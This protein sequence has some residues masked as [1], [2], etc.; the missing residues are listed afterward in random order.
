MDYIAELK[1]RLISGAGL[2]VAGRVLA[3][4]LSF[5]MSAVLAR[6]LSPSD[7]GVYFLMYS[8]VSILAIV[9]QGGLGSA[10]VSLVAAENA[11]GSEKRARELALCALSMGVAVS[12]I[13][14]SLPYTDHGSRIIR[15]VLRSERAAEMPGLL[16]AWVWGMAMTNLIAD[17]YRGF[18]D[19]RSA[20]QY[21]GLLSTGIAFVVLVGF[22]FLERVTLESVVAATVVGVVMSTL[23]GGVPLWQGLR[24]RIAHGFR[25][26]R[27][28]IG[29]AWPLFVTSVGLLVINQ[30]DI[31]ILNA[32]RPH[33]EVATYGAAT[34]LILFA[35]TP[36]VIAYAVIP[37]MIAE[38]H[39]QHR[40]KTLERLLRGVSTVTGLPGF[41]VIG[42]YIVFPNEIMALVYGQYY[43]QGADVLA[44]LAAGNIMVMLSGMAS[45]A[46]M[47]TG[48]Q[49]LMMV[50]TVASGILSVLL[51]LAFVMAYGNEGVAIAVA[52]GT[53]LQY[54]AMLVAT[55]LRVGVWSHVA[56]LRWRHM[57][58]A[59][60]LLVSR[61]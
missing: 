61:T 22:V 35:M 5:G 43:E 36:L 57:S 25:Q 28:L 2:A 37:P 59:A 42:I 39:A 27:S 7:M 49:M 58:E 38:M 4:A 3:V 29:R 40:T 26:A 13:V 60:R 10:V 9:A 30:T 55:R 12:L 15:V 47:M 18:H 21:G 8:L 24:T 34:R 52:I 44:I 16:A 50:I 54:S 32:Y 51:C 14:G 46:L 45:S 41:L 56:M 6:T 23:L 17:T 19:Y 33:E 48:N 31:W 1:R 53:T 20:I 11:S